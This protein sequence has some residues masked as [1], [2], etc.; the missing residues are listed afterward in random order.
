MTTHQPTRTPIR[1]IFI[2]N[3]T[4]ST[5]G[6]LDDE[7]A[8]LGEWKPEKGRWEVLVNDY[9]P[10]NAPPPSDDS[11]RV[12][13]KEANIEDASNEDSVAHVNQ[14]LVDDTLVGVPPVESPTDGFHARF[15]RLDFVHDV[16]MF[17]GKDLPTAL[18]TA[19]AEASVH[20]IIQELARDTLHPHEDIATHWLMSM[21]FGRKTKAGK[22]D[23]KNVHTK[24]SIALYN[25]GCF[26]PPVRLAHREAM[27]TDEIDTMVTKHFEASLSAIGMGTVDNPANPAKIA[28]SQ[29]S[30]KF[31][32]AAMYTS[33]RA[34]Y[35]EQDFG[36]AVLADP[37]L[38]PS[39]PMYLEVIGAL[40]AFSTCIDLFCEFTRA[41]TMMCLAR[42]YFWKRKLNS[43]VKAAAFLQAIK[44]ISDHY[45]KLWKEHFE[46]TVANMITFEFTGVYDN[47]EF[48]EAFEQDNAQ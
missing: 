8:L 11:Y 16:G 12:A 32:H 15:G 29:A 20:V 26:G 43:D 14:R 24:H 7:I 31:I 13:V 21:W 45:P 18:D 3:L 19:L 9:F 33:T 38:N 48:R 37:E 36:K 42:I 30:K 40:I 35:Q 34:L 46:G 39:H 23:L 6:L 17:V 28:T 25:A 1:F 47:K 5:G 44:P 2:R 22:M 41:S 27:E 10:K 4:S